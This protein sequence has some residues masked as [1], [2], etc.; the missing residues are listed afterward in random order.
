M[1]LPQVSGDPSRNVILSCTVPDYGVQMLVP[2]AAYEQSETC[3]TVYQ[4]RSAPCTG[5]FLSSDNIHSTIQGLEHP[6][7]PQP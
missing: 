7:Q 3:C 2:K 4:L 5:D 1:L 6:A